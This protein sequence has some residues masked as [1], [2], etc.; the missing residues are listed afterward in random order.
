MAVEAGKVLWE[1]KQGNDAADGLAVSGA[2]LHHLRGPARQQESQ[3]E[4]A[5]RGL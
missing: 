3:R 2:T 1:D 4:Q 5:A